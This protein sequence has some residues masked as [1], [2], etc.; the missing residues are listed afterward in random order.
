MDWG[1]EMPSEVS[2]AGAGR[3][4]EPTVEELKRELAEAR[5]QQT[6]TAGILAAISKAPSD[7]HRVFAEIAIANE[8]TATIGIGL[9]AEQA[10][11]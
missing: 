1:A 8:L 4:R 9:R 6:A 2:I 7:A 11:M 10:L 5:E 3:D